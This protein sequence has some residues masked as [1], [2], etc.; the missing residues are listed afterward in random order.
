MLT[1]GTYFGKNRQTYAYIIYEWPLRTWM[2]LKSQKKVF[3]YRP[4]L[5]SK[6]HSVNT[7][8]LREHLNNLN[9]DMRTSLISLVSG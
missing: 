1:Q 7:V 9:Y 4:L 6:N 2:G 8:L 5:C 3:Q